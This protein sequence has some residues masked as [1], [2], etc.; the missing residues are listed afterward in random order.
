MALVADIVPVCADGVAG[1]LPAA[2]GAAPLDAEAIIYKLRAA[3]KAAGEMLL[4]AALWAAN[5]YPFHAL[6]LYSS[7]L[8]LD[9][10]NLSAAKPVY[11][12]RCGKRLASA[13]LM[14]PERL[15]ILALFQAFESAPQDSRAVPESEIIRKAECRKLK[16]GRLR[17][18]MP[19]NQ[20][21]L[22]GI[23]ELAQPV[24]AAP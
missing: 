14:R 24:R 5:L 2:D 20:L 8:L 23:A 22:T 16:R 9:I 13:S 19:P 17:L 15:V 21:R 1:A 10:Y 7:I 4:P 3:N 6:F 18:V 12:P 11:S